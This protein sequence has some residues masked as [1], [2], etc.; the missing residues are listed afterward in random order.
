MQEITRIARSSIKRAFSPTGKMLSPLDID[1]DAA[2]GISSFEVQSSLSE[3]GA[4]PD[5]IRKI[6]LWD[7]MAALRFMGMHHRLIGPEV[8]INVGAELA[9]R[10]ARARKR[11][12]AKE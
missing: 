3:I 10:L 1:E 6:K 5:A 9:D 2:A 11:A 4:A 12:R 7:K 8:Q